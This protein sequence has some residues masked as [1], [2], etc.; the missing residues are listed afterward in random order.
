MTDISGLSAPVWRRV[1]DIAA[2]L[3]VQALIG[4]PH[5]LANQGALR[6]RPPTLGKAI[7]AVEASLG[8]ATD[9]PED[10]PLF[11]FSAGWRSGST[12]L[13]RL[14]ISTE[15]DFLWG[16]PYDL[17]DLVRRLAE[18]LRPFGTGWPPANYLYETP[19]TSDL[20]NSTGR[21]LAERWI[22]NLY[23]SVSTLIDS[24]R[25]LVRTL[26]SPPKGLSSV[27]WGMK[28]VRLSADHA[29]YLRLLFP[30]A[31]FV[32]LVRHPADAY[33][34]YKRSL[35]WFDEWPD[36][37]V[38]TPRAFGRMWSRLAASFFDHR[39]DSQTL[40]LRY[41]DLVEGGEAIPRLEEILGRSVNQSVLANRVGGTNPG[42]ATLGPVER[43]ILSRYT[44]RVAHPLGY[45]I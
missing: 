5:V 11:V 10:D 32:F 36:Q 19:A 41:E 24:H 23:P 39:D 40:L 33:A 7:A 8:A 18:S 1:D 35:E 27:T 14:I 13:Q 15:E 26:L 2:R 3:G 43:R 34:S 29:L 6:R 4:K 42:Q 45:R 17:C 9:S 20:H 25:T 21:E 12:L 22:A 16:E 30:R 31:R 44:G 37:Q 28:E 38:R